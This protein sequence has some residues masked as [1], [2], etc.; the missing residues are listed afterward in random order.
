MSTRDL[1]L[2]MMLKLVE[3]VTGPAKKI[4][5]V[6]KRVSKDL[7]GTRDALKQVQD[8]SK[9]VEHLNTLNARLKAHSNKLNDA[10]HRL[11]DL[12]REYNATTKPSKR[13][14][15]QLA[16]AGKRVATLST[17]HNEL[18]K[19]T[20]ELRRELKGAGIDTN[21]LGKAEKHL[22]SEAERLNKRLEKQRRLYGKLQQL[23]HAMA[24]RWEKFKTGARTAAIWGGGA[25]V[26]GSMAFTPMLNKMSEFE[27]Y[28]AIL[29]TVE[30]SSIKAQQSMDWISKFA[31]TTPY[32][33][34]QVTESFVRLKAY[35]LDPTNGLLRTLGDTSAA[36]G[37][38]VMSA[39]EAIADAV[40]GENERLKE[41]GIKA[42][43][44]DDLITYSYTDKNG[45]QKALSA[46]KDDRKGIEQVLRRIWNE[47]YSGAMERQSKTWTGLTS[48]LADQLTR[49]QVMVMKSGPFDR[50]K[51][52]LQD[53]LDKVDAM[54]A[55]G[56]LERWAELMGQKIVLAIDRITEFGQ[57]LWDLGEWLH[58]TLVPVAELAGGWDNLAIAMATVKF[59]PV[60]GMSTALL[61]KLPAVVGLVMKLGPAFTIAATGAR[62][63]ALAL[64]ANP[65]GLVITGIVTV[66]AGAAYLIHKHWD[67][68]SAFLMKSWEWLKSAFFNWT[69]LGLLIKHWDAI[70]DYFKGLPARMA[71]Y[72]RNIIEGLGR[73]IDEKLEWVKEKVSGLGDM[74][75]DWLKE[76]L[77]IHSPSRVFADIGG[78]ISE[79]V[80]AGI[81]KR[82]QSALAA[83]Q[84][85]GKRLPGALPAA[86][87]VGLTA[88]TAGASPL[89]ATP[90]AGGAPVVMH[91]TI[92]VNAAPG[93][94]TQAI[95]EEVARQVTRLQQQAAARSRSQLID[96][97]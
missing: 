94:D 96:E 77:D 76:K 42:K 65:I 20:G 40:T 63:L 2:S 89:Q 78:N 75:P 68:V 74:L 21:K 58:A 34:N 64:I 5:I 57:K 19:K 32:E 69:P 14:T 10:Q 61:G 27:G 7:N 51:G 53:V 81:D 54:A 29:E 71:G 22:S 95:G 52:H 49:F 91:V 26:A 73:G 33:L 8:Q 70:G 97:E 48:N 80:R 47:K 55:S 45:R 62:A 1:K 30:G 17:R 72:G 16:R 67:K 85:L 50:L 31:V 28:Q 43:V 87:A 36:M 82:A 46:M 12:K 66:V 11:K 24:A 93:M 3:K 59:T 38:D 25:L 15:Q 6:S 4:G 79:G 23:P 35:G 60:I 90:T 86:M 56:E 13:L 44:D 18:R 88:N 37:K 92:N 39:V 84:R 41:F 9:K 83:V